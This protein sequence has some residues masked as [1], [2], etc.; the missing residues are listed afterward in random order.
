MKLLIV[1]GDDFGLSRGAN[2]GIVE[3]HARGILTSAS[4]LVDTPFGAAAAQLAAD[5]PEL[6]LGLHADV[7][8]DLDPEACAA[9]IERQ[10]ALF[11]ELVGSWPTHL[12]SHRNVHAHPA[13]AGAFVGV[14][15]RR[16]LPLR[17]HSTARPLPSFYGQWGGQT[18]PERISV[19]GLLSLLGEVEDGVTELGC[20]PGYVD[21]TLESS[22]ADEREIEL[23]TLCDPG[24]RAALAELGIVLTNFH[25]GGAAGHPAR[26]VEP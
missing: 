2:R 25:E 1:N 10:L 18:H 11:R 26:R 19:P 13:L 23:R 7:R 8:P 9:E 21:E 22:Y 6:S 20:H 4:L 14:A 16:G 17:G 15:R 24:L 5:L 3:A 12:D